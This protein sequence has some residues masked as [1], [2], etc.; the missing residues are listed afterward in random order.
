[1]MRLF[2]FKINRILFL[3][4][5]LM[6]QTDM[7]AQSSDKNYVQT[8]TFLDEDGLTFLRHIDYYD[9]LGVVSETVD[10][11][12]NTTNTPIVKRTEYDP[13]LKPQYQWAAV[14][15]TGLG[16][17]DEDDVYD[18][19]YDT[20]RD[21]TPYSRNKYDDFQELTSTWKPG[22]EWN[23]RPVTIK[24]NVAPAGVVK[25]YT[26]DSNGNLCVNDTYPYGLL[27]STTTT[28]E[29][30]RSMTVYTDFHGNSILERRGTGTDAT[31]TYYVYDDYGRLRYVLPPMC[32]HCSTSEMSKYWYKY[33]Y[34]DRGRCTEKQLPGC[35]VVKYWYDNANR[36]LSEQ[37]KHLRSQS[38]YRNYSYDRTGRLTLQTISSTQG[39][40]YMSNTVTTEK[41]NFY[42]NYSFRSELA[43]HFPEWAVAINSVNPLLQ[44]AKGRLTATMEATSD[45]LKYME[46]YGYDDRGNMS[47]KL[48]AYDKK[49]MKIVQTVYNFARDAVSIDE[50]VYNINY[51]YISLLAGR[52]T[53]NT[54]HLGTRL[55]ASTTVTYTDKNGNTSSQTVSNPSYDVFGNVV[56]NN[57]PGSAADMAYNYDTLH[58]WL[59]DI[60]SPGGF[61]EQ[62][63]RENAA[64]P[65]FSGNIGSMEWRN[66][67]NGEQHRYDYTYDELGRLTNS[68]Y[69]SSVM[70][71]EGRFDESLTYNK[72]G[73]I[74]TL[75]RSG[76][77]NDGTFGT[78]DDLR[79]SYNGNRLLKV[80][81]E[82][83]AVNYNGALDFH[84]G[85][86]TD[87]EYEYDSNGALTKDSNR[88]IT[89]ITYDYGHHPYFIDM[90]QGR[91]PRYIT[92]DYTPDG[93]KL[94]SL[95][96][97]TISNANGNTKKTTTDLYIDGLILRDGKPLLWQFDG[98]Y[99]DLDANGAA[100]SWNYYVTDHLGSTRKVVDSNNNIKETIN[101]YPFGSEMRMEI[102]DQ[103][104]QT[105]DTNHP[106]RFTCK[107]LDKQN[108]LNMYDFGARLFDVAGVPM[109]TSVDPLAEKFYP[110]S[111]YNYCAG[112]PVNKFD[113]DGRMPTD[114]EAAM[115]SQHV[116]DGKT[117]LEGGWKL[118]GER[119]QL[120]NGL[121][122]GIYYKENEGSTEYVLAFGGSRE[123]SDYV[124]DIK[125]AM[126][127][128]DS[129]Y[130]MAKELGEKFN[131]LYDKYE[132][133]I[134]GHS[135][136][137]GLSQVASMATGIDAITFNP[138]AVHNNTKNALGLSNAPTN[139]IKNIIVRGDIV[140]SVQDAS[141]FANSR[142][143]VEGR[144][145]YIGPRKHKFSLLEQFTNHVIQ[146]AINFLE[147]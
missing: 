53:T 3:S 89:D 114:R 91:K 57:R 120:E 42:D 17:I 75:Q 108:G 71:T 66:T 140:T 139:Q 106:F 2:R 32:Q 58:G 112:D 21:Y 132:K 118:N 7:F 105:E 92:N 22:D 16:Y 88:G 136:G 124:T 55:L 36:L 79:I 26:V 9:E 143:N 125:Q 98:G 94:S 33:T 49:W 37:D 27:M 5:M 144:R 46:I 39:D 126:G 62:L 130:G 23:E 11:G 31:D 34:D 18:A 116:Y 1:M 137:G 97:M 115:I 72:N 138:A 80:T 19:A 43:Y 119:Q 14:P 30:E 110:Y 96:K 77:K 25:K 141:N 103:M 44:A 64:S 83:E 15:S 104:Q 142:L 111:P 134:V 147:K 70:G 60:S 51:G 123:Y 29:D 145:K 41:K 54:Y 24:R 20:Y 45:G 61:S 135:L 100:T 76:M 56:T 68:R 48:S 99:V 69:S 52:T 84:D 12:G 133:T 10:V 109:W 146:T 59:K 121:T 107:E 74:M 4:L 93:R 6:I 82:A 50:R 86:D 102:P 90:S 38:L 95:H 131:C 117:E 78:I 101:Y 13:L 81:D 28:D 85:A 35:G 73:S 65:Q 122:Y 129:Q 8:K 127:M 87:C 113:P 67:S 47:Y 128:P 40:A 63:L